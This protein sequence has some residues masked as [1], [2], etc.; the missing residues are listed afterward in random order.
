MTERASELI[1]RLREAWEPGLLAMSDAE[2]IVKEWDEEQALAECQRCHGADRLVLCWKCA[3]A[4]CADGIPAS[5]S[6]DLREALRSDKPWSCVSVL[7]R[8]AQEAEPGDRD[9]HGHEEVTLACQLAREMADNLEH[10]LAHSPLA[11]EAGELREAAQK[12]CDYY[13]QENGHREYIAGRHD[14]NMR[15]LRAL[16]TK[17]RT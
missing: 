9:F 11:S 1:R 12:V 15:E 17:G 10:A 7:R 6:P 5:P 8:L 13:F 14:E 16:L 2:R 3:D 4:L